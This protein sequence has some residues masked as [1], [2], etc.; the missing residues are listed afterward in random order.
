MRASESLLRCHQGAHQGLAY[1]LVVPA[2]QP[3]CL[4]SHGCVYSIRSTGRLNRFNGQGNFLVSTSC[5]RMSELSMKISFDFMH[6]GS[7]LQALGRVT[8]G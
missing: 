5:I 1:I 4:G 2:H 7:A 8:S 6:I 3:D